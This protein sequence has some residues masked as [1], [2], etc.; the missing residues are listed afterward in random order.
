MLLFAIGSSIPILFCPGII[1]ILADCADIDIA[2]SSA[3]PTTLV[4]FVPRDGSNS[5][6]VTTGPGLIS[7]IS[8]F[9]L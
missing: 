2:I 7:V 4:D 5:K 6:S 3:S 9:T 8:P 1:A